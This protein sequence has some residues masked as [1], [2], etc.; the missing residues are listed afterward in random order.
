MTKSLDLF[1]HGHELL[2]TFSLNSISQIVPIYFVTTGFPKWVDISVK[3]V[4]IFWDLEWLKKHTNTYDFKIYDIYL[5]EAE[6]FR[7]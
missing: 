4:N 1:K 3:K 5:K 2:T 7:V 6:I